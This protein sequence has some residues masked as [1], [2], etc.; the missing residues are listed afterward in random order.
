VFLVDRID[1][2]SREKMMHLKAVVFVRPTEENARFIEEELKAPHYS[3]Y[4]LYF[5][6]RLE[7]KHLD[8]LAMADESELVREV[9]EY[10]ADFFPVTSDLFSLGLPGTLKLQ[11]RLD[12]VTVNGC[13]LCC[14][15]RLLLPCYSRCSIDRVHVR[16][17]LQ[18]PF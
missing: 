3:E 7:M 15:A 4:H 12:P 16:C 18:R 8:R 13:C 9:Q 1:N 5:S 10:Y 6:N 17:G 2:A 11:V 14:A